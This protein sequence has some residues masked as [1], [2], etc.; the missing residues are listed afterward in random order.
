MPGKHGSRILKLTVG[1]FAFTVFSVMLSAFGSICS[2]V[3]GI[4]PRICALFAAVLC[5]VIFCRSSSALS[6]FN[7]AIGIL[8]G[9]GIAFS[10]FYILMYRE[11]PTFSAVPDAAQSACIYSGYNL[12]SVIPSLVVLSG[13][14]KSKV[15]AAA[16]P[17]ISG[18]AICILMSLIFAILSMYSVRIPLGEFPM[19]TMAAR[20][21]NGFM[22]FYGVMLAA[23]IISTLFASSAGIAES[24]GN[25]RSLIFMLLISMPAYALSGLGFGKLVDTLYRISGIIGIIIC[26][27]ISI[28]CIKKLIK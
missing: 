9:S 7:G 26:T 3:T 8:L 28:I 10:C 1:V 27:A 16:V 12:I 5:S 22:I 18:M 20:Q 6:A 23:A 15:D 17:L 11:H 21:S 25:R 2:I 4:S 24:A 19:L 14:L 13:K